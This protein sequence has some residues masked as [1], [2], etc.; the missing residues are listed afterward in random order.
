MRR[1]V[2]EN[3]EVAEQIRGGWEFVAAIP[4]TN[5]CFVKLPE[6]YP[7]EAV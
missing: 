5:Q 4:G 3:G 6:G 1:K 2:V 7:G